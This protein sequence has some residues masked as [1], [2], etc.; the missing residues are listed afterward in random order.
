MDG[1]AA[2]LRKK[3]SGIL[4]L[5]NEKQ[6]RLL[7]GAEAQ[8]IGYGGIKIL[9][10]VTGMDCKTVRRG[11]KELKQRKKQLGRIRIKGGGRKK[12]LDQE[13]K[14]KRI[15]VPKAFKKPKKIFLLLTISI[16]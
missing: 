5:L 8:S 14:I 10:D 11:V 12:I 6:R 3:L 16:L 13:P 1:I 7:V 2:K 15:I 4:F 9:S